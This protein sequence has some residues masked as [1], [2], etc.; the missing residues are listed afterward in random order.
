MTDLE[1]RYATLPIEEAL[2]D[3]PHPEFK[4]LPTE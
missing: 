3:N 1:R 4:R 2:A